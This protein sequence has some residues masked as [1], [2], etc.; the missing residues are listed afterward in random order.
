MAIA[1]ISIM[2]WVRRDGVTPTVVL[3]RVATP[4]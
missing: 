4:R 2:K 1:S 3:V